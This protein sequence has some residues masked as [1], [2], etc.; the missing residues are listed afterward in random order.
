MGQQAH[1]NRQSALDAG[2][3]VRVADGGIYLIRIPET[4]IF[5]QD[6][7][8]DSPSVCVDCKG[9]HIYWPLTNWLIDNDIGFVV[10]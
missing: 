6:Y 3:D 4:D 8:A 5:M 10:S 7:G 1:F 2:L 9:S